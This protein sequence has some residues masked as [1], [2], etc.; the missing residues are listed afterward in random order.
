VR[1]VAADGET[2]LLAPPDDPAAFAAAVERL[3][4]D[5]ALAARLGAAAARAAERWSWDARAAAL[6]DFL[7][8]IARPQAGAPRHAARHML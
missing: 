3:L 4:G 7:D 1:A 5:P 8:R 6:A 2:A